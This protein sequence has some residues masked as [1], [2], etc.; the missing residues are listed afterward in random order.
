MTEHLTF[1]LLP[2]AVTELTNEIGELKITA[3]R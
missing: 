1:D 3:I 2:K